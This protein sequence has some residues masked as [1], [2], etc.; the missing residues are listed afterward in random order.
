MTGPRAVRTRLAATPRSMPVPLTILLAAFATA[1]ALTPLVALACRRLGFVDEPGVRKVHARSTPV[2]GGV[3]V[4]AAVAL[5]LGVGLLLDDRIAGGLRLEAPIVVAFAAALLVF[6]V[7]VY[8]DLF[9]LGARYKLVAQVVIASMLSIDGVRIDAIELGPDWSVQL[10]WLAAPATVVWL[11]GLTNAVNLIDGMDGLAS[12]IA[13]LGAAVVALVAWLLGAFVVAVTMLAV[14]GALLGFLL[15]NFH[16]ARIFLGDSGSLFLGFLIAAGA[17]VAGAGTPS[18]DLLGLAFVG[19]SVPILDTGFAMLR[20]FLERRSIFAPDRNHLH[21]RLLHKGVPQRRAAL[22][23]WVY[24]AI[25]IGLAMFALRT[26]PWLD[27]L[28]FGVV[29]LLQVAVFRYWGAVRLKEAWRALRRKRA[30]ARAATSERRCFEAIELRF[31]EADAFEQ[32]WAVVTQAA[33]ELGIAR[34]DLVMEPLESGKR[35]LTWENGERFDPDAPAV[36]MALPIPQSAA[37]EPAEITVTAPVGRDSLEAI[38]RRL[39]WL[40]RLLDE[41]SIAQLPAARRRARA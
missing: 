3:A 33:D 28:L 12:G 29:V 22:L 15:F 6:G 37:G 7:G 38:T 27:L 10:G 41:H 35:H 18:L 4:V 9:G 30:I 34:L 26:G 16:P 19:L 39:T 23:L 2:L 13:A 21:H 36:R 20:R 25:P 14:V 11:V 31:R 40:G 17:L 8:D 32:W 1:L 24:A 5:A